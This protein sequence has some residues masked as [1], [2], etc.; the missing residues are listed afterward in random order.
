MTS[1]QSISLLPDVLYGQL[2]FDIQ[3]G[4]VFP[5]T[6]TFVDSIPDISPSELIALYEREK[7]LP[8]FNLIEF[9]NKHF[10]LQTDLGLNYKSNPTMSAKDHINELWNVLCRP[11][12]IRV[13][14]SSIIP[15]PY[16][17]IV[18]GG[19]FRE[20]FYWDSYFTMLGLILIPERLSI[21]K[22]MIDNFAYMIDQFGFI[23]N[24]NRTY[25]LSRSQPPFFAQMVHLLADVDHT[26]NIRQ[27]YLSHLRKEYDW[28][29]KDSDQLTEN[30]PVKRVSLLIKYIKSKY[31][32]SLLP[33]F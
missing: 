11:T 27:R 30:E 33:L 17:Y 5:D 29:M 24:G 16:P 32:T 9:V 10:H 8:N 14:G 23:P 12:D 20:I 31:L 2:Y 25:F 22:S 19:R 26:E 21:V 6:K 18:P 4:H 28:W 13:E 1:N 7:L 3:L 15:L